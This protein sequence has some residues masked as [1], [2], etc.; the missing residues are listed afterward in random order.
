M[1]N[2]VANI[3]IMFQLQIVG[4]P[5]KYNNTSTRLLHILKISSDTYTIHISTQIIK[6]FV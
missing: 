5:A 3:P 2:L 1:S 4:F 6:T